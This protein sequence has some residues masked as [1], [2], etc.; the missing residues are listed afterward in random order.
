MLLLW[1]KCNRSY[2]AVEQQENS[3]KKFETK[4]QLNLWCSIYMY[5]EDGSRWLAFF[6][7]IEEKLIVLFL[8]KCEMT[9]L[10]E[11]SVALYCS[12][13]CKQL[14]VRQLQK[15]I[16][17]IWEKGFAYIQALNICVFFPS[18]QVCLTGP[19]QTCSPF[20]SRG[21]PLSPS[22]TMQ[23]PE[24]QVR[25]Y[26]KR[27]YVLLT[28]WVYLITFCSSTP[29]VLLRHIPVLEPSHLTN[30]Q[31]PI[32]TCHSTTCGVSRHGRLPDKTKC[33]SESAQANGLYPQLARFP[34][35]LSQLHLSSLHQVRP[36]VVRRLT[37]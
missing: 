20:P 11:E 16:P 10:T 37:L 28:F 21:L 8:L 12:A 35:G 5:P 36:A 4:L 17:N 9:D 27:L 7:S 18:V 1:S 30:P 29:F 32:F 6:N 34:A 19:M 26:I 25:Q 13:L 3:F 33:Q 31:P 2:S 22:P 14:T 15:S 24:G 23:V